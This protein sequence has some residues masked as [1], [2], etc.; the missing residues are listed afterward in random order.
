VKLVKAIPQPLAFLGLFLPD[1]NAQLVLTFVNLFLNLCPRVGIGRGLLHGKMWNDVR[2]LE[3]KSP[4]IFVDNHMEIPLLFARVA[5]A[6]AH[7]L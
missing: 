2:G 7:A 6:N 5:D 1:S 4:A 3:T